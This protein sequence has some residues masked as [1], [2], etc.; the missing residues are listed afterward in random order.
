MGLDMYLFVQKYVPHH[1]YGSS[2]REVNPMF[3]EIIK[4]AKLDTLPT[5]DF[6][7]VEVIKQVGYWR[8]ANAIHGWIVRNCAE[9]IDECQKI[10]LKRED[11]KALRDSCMK[12][13]ANR[14][15]ALPDQEDTKA[16]KLD[17]NGDPD[18]VIKKLM[19]VMNAE[20]EK[21]NN[22]ITTLA[23]PLSLEPTSGFFFG[24]TTKDEYYYHTIEYTLDLMNSLLAGLNPNE[25]VYYQAS[26]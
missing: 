7:S 21:V 8:K 15:N 20:G 18:S 6:A 16:I 2:E 22:T 4:S 11:I 26:W 14:D 10:S 23:D 12:E 25:Y 19:E 9:G 3:N 5:S 17:D 13:L 24:G 1:E